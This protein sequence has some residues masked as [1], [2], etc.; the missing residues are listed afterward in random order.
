MTNYRVDWL[1]DVE[2]DLARYWLHHPHRDAVTAAQHWIDQMLAQEPHHA[3][4]ELEEGLW[5]VNCSPLRAL[6][7]IDDTHKTVTVTALHEIP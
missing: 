1:P 3:G 2:D 5:A 4:T 6:Y 7:E